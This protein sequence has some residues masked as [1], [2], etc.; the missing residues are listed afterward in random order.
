MWRT[1]PATGQIGPSSSRAVAASTSVAGV[2]TTVP[3]MA[4]ATHGDGQLMYTPSMCDEA[5][6]E[7]PGEGCHHEAAPLRG[8]VAVVGQQ[9]EAV[10]LQRCQAPAVVEVDRR[11]GRTGFEM[12]DGA[13]PMRFHRR[14]RS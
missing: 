6:V 12:D 7:S 14:E 2:S 10:D 9:V 8:G 11:S 13:M 4:W 3:W 1:W 5:T